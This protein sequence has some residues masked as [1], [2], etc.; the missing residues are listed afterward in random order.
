M[1]STG[2]GH[3]CAIKVDTRELDGLTEK[4]H[5]L[6]L[7]EVE[8]VHIQLVKELASKVIQKVMHTTPVDTGRLISGYGAGP[9]KSGDPGGLTALEVGRR[10]DSYYIYVYNNTYYAEYV[11]WGHRTRDLNG[12]VQGQYYFLI[13]AMEVEYEAPSYVEKRI[14]ALLR[15]KLGR[16]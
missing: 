4:L 16:L 5:E 2:V 9:D 14:E 6:R 7:N 15:E 3:T 12:W 8:K 13:P 11:D 10:G 1:R